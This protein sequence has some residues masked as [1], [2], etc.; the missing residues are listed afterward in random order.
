MREGDCAREARLG[1]WRP[2]WFVRACA[3]W[4]HAQGLG[5]ACVHLSRA[6]LKPPQKMA[7]QRALGIED[8]RGVSRDE[9]AA[10]LMDVAEGRLP[11]DRIAL[12]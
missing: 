2:C 3:L 7:E 9:M 10:A 12:K 8:S 11:K 6:A 4:Q 1:T 5:H